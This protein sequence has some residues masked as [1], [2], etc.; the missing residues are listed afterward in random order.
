MVEM[1]KIKEFADQIA[2]EFKPDRIILFGSH[3]YGNPSPGSDVDMLV[4]MPFRGKSY[5]K[6]LEIQER[7]EPGFPLDL[8]VRTPKQ[9]KKRLEWNDFFIR[10][11]IEQGRVLYEADNS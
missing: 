11:I 2:R 1:L 8:I 6:S 5:K 7:I 4:I 10:E 3:A 9:I